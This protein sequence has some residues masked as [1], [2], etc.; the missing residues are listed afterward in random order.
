MRQFERECWLA[1]FAR[2]AGVDEAGRGPLAG[3]VVA[4]CVVLPRRLP[5]RLAG[6]DDSKRLSEARREGLY[7]A[8]LE[9]VPD[10]GV[11][12][13]SPEEIDALNILN[14]TFLAMRRAIAEV[15][16]VAHVLVDGN[17]RV[18]EL[19]LP[20]RPIV[21]GDARSA[22]IAAASIVAKVTRDR[23][24]AECEAR[25]PGYG[26][27]RHK[28]YGTAAHY[29]ALAPLGPCELHRRSFLKGLSGP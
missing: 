9:L 12:Q 29:E 20:Q 27:A 5:K 26:F 7:A 18:R 16:G 13:A 4:A 8:L 24:M 15:P 22:A 28:G 1:G 23:L 6:L 21:K 3:P 17:Q 10:V 2:V 14:A 19:T 25:F 11:G